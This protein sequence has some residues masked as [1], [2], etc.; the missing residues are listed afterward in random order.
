METRPLSDRFELRHA[1]TDHALRVTVPARRLLAID[2]FGP[3]GTPDFL[4]ALRTL[5]SAEQSIRANLAAAG[6]Q[7]LVPAAAESIWRPEPRVA[8]DEL[9]DS[10]ASR[11]EWRWVQLAELP[12]MAD[13]ADAAAAIDAVRQRAGREQPLIRVVDLHEGESLQIL[14]VGGPGAEGDVLRHLLEAM[15]A[16]GQ[17]PDRAV[18]QIF[19]SDPARVPRD[20][21]R[22][23]LRIAMTP[24]TRDDG[25]AEGR[26]TDH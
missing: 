1:A 25:Q 26:T 14:A 5:R 16:E 23:I 17:E 4:L 24:G 20:R 12:T 13:R 22:S 9:V 10:F 15:R 2:G 18:H 7:G 11:S 8:G 6:W 3:P 19:V 21:W